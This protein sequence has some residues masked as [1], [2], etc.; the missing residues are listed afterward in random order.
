M[1]TPGLPLEDWDLPP[2]AA[3]RRAADIRAWQH[4]R[5]AAR[6]KARK[7]AAVAHSTR[8]AATTITNVLATPL[9]EMICNESTYQAVLRDVF[10]DGRDL[11]YE[12]QLWGDD[13]LYKRVKIATVPLR[14]AWTAREVN[15]EA[16][17]ASPPPSDPVL[18]ELRE[19]ILA[20]LVN[21][22]VAAPPAPAEHPATPAPRPRPGLTSLPAGT[23]T[24]E[25]AGLVD[26]PVSG[27]SGAGW[28]EH[29]FRHA[30]ASAEASRTSGTNPDSLH[31]RTAAL[32]E[33]VSGRAD[34]G[35][36]STA[37]Q[38]EPG[39]AAGARRV[40]GARSALGRL[41]ARGWALSAAGVAVMSAGG[42][43]T[44]VLATRGSTP[45]P[46]CAA[47]TATQ[48]IVHFPPDYVGPVYLTVCAAQP[49]AATFNVHLSW[50]PLEA[51]VVLHD[52]SGRGSSLTTAKEKK[53]DAT[54]L[55]VTVTP[56]A[57]VGYGQGIPA[58]A[59]D[60]DNIWVR[61]PTASG[62]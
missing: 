28:A 36:G 11:P 52:V 50:G 30:P 24:A 8:R 41:S 29:T 23:V 60:I 17:L 57:R 18:A 47:T 19:A 3:D 10:P 22:P 51:S 21:G 62:G 7:N 37:T 38:P 58:G 54:P 2:E 40:A 49:T 9:W 46:Q 12:G 39:G 27:L 13:G 32:L 56:P 53:P 5:A 16:W 55:T 25:D 35:G 14:K 4:L 15:R 43:I 6:S 33:P 26:G 44:G 61:K 20:D 48:T 42:V 34:S 59:L 1:Q 31:G 45:G